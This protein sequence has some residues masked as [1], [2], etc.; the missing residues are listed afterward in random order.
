[1]SAKPSILIYGNCQGEHLAHIARQLTDVREAFG[2]KVIP[3]QHVTERDWETRYNEA[4]FADVRVVWNQVESGEATV[5]R[6][7]LESRLPPNCQS[8]KFPPMIQLSV[9]PFSGS[10][11]RIAAATDY[12]YPWAD[13]IAASLAPSVTGEDPPDDVLFAEYMRLSTDKMPDLECRLRL[14]ASRARAGDEL[15]D[16]KMWDWIEENFRTTQLFHTSTHLTAL[17]FAYLV[18]RLLA[19]TG[20]LSVAQ[21]AGAQREGAFPMR[22]NRGQDIETVPVHP[23]IAERMGL[24]W[25]DPNARHRWHS[26]FWTY[27][28]YILKYIRWEPFMP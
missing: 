15:A 27:R 26:H 7:I 28:E 23:L 24:A 3:L 1:M 8:I 20:D 2:I 6:G 17:P 25:Y 18:P 16:I 22:G 5:H 10:D 11:P 4:F 14:D 9:W 19:L 13:S 12:V 21:V